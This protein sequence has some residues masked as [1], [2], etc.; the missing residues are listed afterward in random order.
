MKRQSRKRLAQLIEQYPAIAKVRSDAFGTIVGEKFPNTTVK[1]QKPDL[2]LM[3]L[4]ARNHPNPKRSWV[5]SSH[6]PKR[7]GSQR[8]YL[9]AIDSRDQIIGKLWEKDTFPKGMVKEIFLVAKQDKVAYLLWVRENG[10]Y[11]RE[12]VSSSMP[13]RE[14][15]VIIFPRRKD[16]S[17]ER[18]VGLADRAET[19]RE[20]AFLYHPK[21]MPKLLWVHQ[22]LQVGYHLRGFSSGGGLRVVILEKTKKKKSFYGEHPHVEEALNY[23]DE[24]VLAGGRPY[25]KV[26]GKKY[27]HYLTGAT[28]S[29]SNIDSWLRWGHTFECWQEG[30]IIFFKLRGY[31]KYKI[32]DWVKREVEFRP[33][34][35]IQWKDRGFTFTTVPKTYGFG[36]TIKV[37]K[38]PKESQ[39]KDPYL[40]KVTRTGKGKKLWEAM[41]FAFLAPQ[42]EIKD[43]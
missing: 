42:V 1:V 21:V 23:L 20:K 4:K 14:L 43:D 12:D 24:D 35:P 11:P 3:H 9:C 5:M 17:W 39:G 25:K 16:M 33:G 27:P 28:V 36:Y 32:P 34:E 26:Y 41:A 13:I 8:E 37:V 2:E 6:Y 40:I 30:K 38:S 19:E 18:L 22:A 7:V 10:W 15:T 31:A 29:T